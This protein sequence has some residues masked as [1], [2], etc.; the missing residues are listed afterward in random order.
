MSKKTTAGPS[1]SAD[2]AGQENPNG[3]ISGADTNTGA[4]AGADEG[5]TKGGAESDVDQ[6]A[7]LREPSAEALA[8]AAGLEYPVST[9]LRNNGHLTV[10]E[11]VTS[12]LVGGGAAVNVTLHDEGHAI[13][14]LGNTMQLNALHF[15]G[16]L[17]VRLDAAPDELYLKG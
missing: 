1:A 14:I 9:I 5:A 16:D 7:T 17:K 15:Q 13:S 3:A 4:D 10:V 12:Q 6:G 2:G 8:W 11:P